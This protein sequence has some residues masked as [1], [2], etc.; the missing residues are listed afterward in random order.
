MRYG[1]D[2]WV[3]VSGATNDLGKEFCH[4]FS[5]FGFN[6]LMVDQNEDELNALKESLSKIGAE[7]A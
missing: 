5:K 4:H 2:T 7:N 1:A 3:V 6:I